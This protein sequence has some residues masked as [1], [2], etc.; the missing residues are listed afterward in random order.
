MSRFLATI[1]LLITLAASGRAAFAQTPLQVALEAA[2]TQPA[3]AAASATTQPAAV[4][5]AVVVIDKSDKERAETI[6]EVFGRTRVGELFQGK[7]KVTLD[8]VKDP[9][10]WIDT[11]RDLV[12]AVLGFIPRIIV[13]GLFL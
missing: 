7:K 5:P 3:A 9:A 13:A 12:I 6:G 2:T 11:V 10:F 4:T 1:I 8:D